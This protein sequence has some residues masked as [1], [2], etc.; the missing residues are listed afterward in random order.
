MSFAREVREVRQLNAHTLVM[1]EIKRVIETWVYSPGQFLPSERDLALQLNVSRNTLRQAAQ[2]LERDGVIEVLR[3]REGGY[4]VCDPALTQE[5]GEDIRRDPQRFIDVW[6][7]MISVNVTAARL[8]AERRTADDIVRLRRIIDELWQ[9]WDRYRADPTLECARSSHALD[10][11]LYVAIGDAT[12]NAYVTE[13]LIDCRRNLWDAYSAIYTYIDLSNQPRRV[14]IVDA[15]ATG[16]AELAGS[17]MHDHGRAGLKIFTDWCENG[18]TH[19]LVIEAGRPTRT[20]TSRTVIR[21]HHPSQG[22]ELST[23]GAPSRE[24]KS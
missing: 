19:D 10:L 7:F 22:D 15:I 17:L 2:Q 12:K 4:L 24:K 8:A 21:P 5:H 13:A 14:G 20:G 6:E 23:S 11:R 16:D 1:E 18:P 3:G 9:V